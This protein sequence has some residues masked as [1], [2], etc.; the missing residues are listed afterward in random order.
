[1]KSKILEMKGGKY[2]KTLTMTQVR[3]IF[4]IR[5]IVRNV[6]PKLIEIC[7]DSPCWCMADGKEKLKQT[8]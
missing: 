6:L 1:M 8:T 3:I 2:T 4:R 5:E 7:M